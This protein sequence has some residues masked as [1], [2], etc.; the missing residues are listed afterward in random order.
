MITA[1][2][3]H[4][5]DEGHANDYVRIEFDEPPHEA[6]CEGSAH[7][8]QQTNKQTKSDVM[9]CYVMRLQTMLAWSMESHAV[10]TRRAANE[11]GS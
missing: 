8:L 4:L 9:L 5:P 6:E 7:V 10:P 11:N 3:Q 1:A 2:K